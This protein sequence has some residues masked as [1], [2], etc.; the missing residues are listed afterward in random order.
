MDLHKTMEIQK[1]ETGLTTQMLIKKMGIKPATYYVRQREDRF[2]RTDLV[3]I[4]KYLQFSDE[5]I[6]GVMK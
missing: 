4:F 1:I 3:K 2:T 6:A 5:Q